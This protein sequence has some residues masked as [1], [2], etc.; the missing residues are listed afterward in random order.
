VCPIGSSRA[1]NELRKH[2]PADRQLPESGQHTKQR[3]RLGRAI[4][5]DIPVAR[6]AQRQVLRSGE[7][8]S[9]ASDLLISAQLNG[10]AVRVDL[11][12]VASVRVISA[13]SRSRPT[14]L[15]S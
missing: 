8:E 6:H 7:A 12:R 14:K 3:I 4:R 15:V 10:V 2:P 1:K 11:P 9:T 5:G 13:I